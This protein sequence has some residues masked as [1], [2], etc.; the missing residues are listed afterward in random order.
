MINVQILNVAIALFTAFVALCL[1]LVSR[2]QWQ[3]NGVRS[4][5]LASGLIALGHAL[6]ASSYF[7][8]PVWLSFYAAVHLIFLGGVCHVWGCLCFFDRGPKLR[9]ILLI[10]TTFFLAWSTL[11]FFEYRLAAGVLL[12]MGILCAN[13]MSMTILLLFRK[14]VPF[15]TLSVLGVGFLLVFLVY[16]ECVFEDLFFPIKVN[17]NESPH[18]IYILCAVSLIAAQFAKGV[19]FLMLINDRLE[20]TLRRSAELDPLTGVLNRRGLF[21]QAKQQASLPNVNQTR[22]AILM[23]DVDHF[24]AVNDQY[25]HQIGDVVLQEIAKRI[26]D[27]LRANDFIARYGGEEFIV[28]LNDIGGDP[29]LALSAAERMRLAV[30]SSPL[31]HASEDITLTIS[32]GICSGANIGSTFEARIAQ[33]DAAL[34]RAKREGRNRVVVDEPNRSS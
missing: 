1:M 29:E 16:L 18:W 20:Q 2:Q 8:F 11:L 19:G 9:G 32:I 33:A 12:W 5:L 23:L 21:H 6:N 17:M 7:H 28:L 30:S 26:G 25:G 14:R 22:Q 4:W 15:G 27:I 24:K 31:L 34:Y 13:A 3:Q 10:V